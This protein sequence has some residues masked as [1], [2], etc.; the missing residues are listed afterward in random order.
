M[1]IVGV[2][3]ENGTISQYKLDNGKVVNKE[4]CINM[5]KKGKIEDCNI[6]TNKKMEEFIR[7]NRNSEDEN[8]K[9]ITNLNDLPTF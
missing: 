9:Q 7:T 2:H 1:K 4:K 8:V 6:G 3:K 5:V